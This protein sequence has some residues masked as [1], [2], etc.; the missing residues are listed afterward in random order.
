MK[1][2]LNESKL[3]KDSISIISELVTEAVFKID[4]NCLEL[5]AMDPANVAMVN[6]KLLASA[7]SEYEVGD[8][9]TLAVNLNTLKQIMRRSKPSD[10]VTL[11]LEGAKLKVTLDGKSKREFQ[12]PT[13][14]IEEK[15]QK[16]PN[17]SFDMEVSIPSSSFSAAIEDVEIV[18]EAV[19]L[20]VEPNKFVVSSVA[21]LSKVKVDLSTDESIKIVTDSSS[22]AKYSVEYLKKML[23]GSKISDVVTLKFKNDYPLKL[24]FVNLNK[25]SIEFILAPR[26]DED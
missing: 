15:D 9:T 11:E 16:V 4:K 1:L 13:L 2:T 7:F 14:D 21:D 25:L 24:E 6:Y 26:M 22:K 12:I 3:L 20:F 18:G 19:S 8:S 17:L 5:I 23:Q 10:K